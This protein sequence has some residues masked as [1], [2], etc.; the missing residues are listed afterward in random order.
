MELQCE[1]ALTMAH[2]QIVFLV[3]MAILLMEW[4]NQQWSFCEFAEMKTIM[5]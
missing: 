3:D 5:K 4:W 2:Y 1:S